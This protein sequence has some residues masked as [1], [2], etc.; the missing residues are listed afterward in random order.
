L[1]SAGVI[2]VDRLEELLDVSTLALAAPLAA[3]RRVALVGNSGGPLIL[4]ADACEA[5]G[6]LVTE[7][8]ESTQKELAQCLVAAA[9][10]SNPVDLTAD[11]RSESLERAL[12][13]VLGD[14]TIDAVIVVVTEVLA[15]S[16]DEARAAAERV[17][18]RFDKPIVACVLGGTP[19]SPEHALHRVA[20]IPSPERA[21]SALAHLCRYAQWRNRPR[22]SVNE[23]VA[24]GQ[25]SV[26]REIVGAFLAETPA[27]GW[28]ELDEAARLLSSCGLPIL[29]TRAASSADEAAVVAESLGFPVVLKARA[30]ELV[31]KSDVGGVVT[32]LA[33]ASAVHAAYEEMSQRLGD[34][35]GGAVLQP[36]AKAGVEAIVGLTVDPD[37]G[38]VVMVGLGGVMTDVLGDRA[39]AVPPLDAGA[40]QAMVSS[41]RAAPLL[42]G[43]RGSLPVDRQALAALVE[44]VARVA[45][46][47]PELVE[48]DLNPVIVTAE[49]A[50]VVDCKARLA[51]RHLGPG[52]LF[53]ALRSRS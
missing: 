38:S 8:D 46:E 9:A 47:V 41:L 2:K 36:M 18:S 39:F 17:A 16:G 25:P 31:H 20:E 10:T 42:D 48:L 45:E 12:E 23:P 44:L 22:I 49:G 51:P 11:G 21:A 4:A 40:G 50:L 30:G 33:S 19:S 35:M 37:F 15:L 27:G 7:L 1:R 43:F 34:Q 26:V 32:S 29:N 5:N 13:I 6:L 14:T 53:R 3:G 28:L 52:P 24:L